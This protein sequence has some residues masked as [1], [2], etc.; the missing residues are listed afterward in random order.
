[1]HSCFS[2]SCRGA[3]Q[4]LCRK[5]GEDFLYAM[6]FRDRWL[7]HDGARGRERNR[8]LWPHRKYLFGNSIRQYPVHVLFPPVDVRRA[9][10]GHSQRSNRY[11]QDSTDGELQLP[12][13]P[14]RYKYPIYQA[15]PS[16]GV[17]VR[18][19]RLENARHNIHFLYG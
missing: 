7:R 11:S 15:V 4:F 19:R 3:T 2:G 6:Q 9:F 8:T 10:S 18:T 1:M 12:K 5:A 13:C 17:H 14:Y 16:V